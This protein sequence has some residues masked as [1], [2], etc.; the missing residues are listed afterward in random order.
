M[1]DP[2]AEEAIRVAKSILDGSTPIFLGCRKL[3]RP[4]FKLY[5]RDDE[6]FSRIAH[7]ADKLEEYPTAETRHLW[8]PEVV[9][10]KD[11]E[12]AA[13]LPQVRDGVLEACREIVRR[14]SE[15]G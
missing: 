1:D 4:L 3:S 8:N 9:A 14:F 5:V 13:W 15:G 12:L 11:A 6:P 10:K 2:Y 7:V